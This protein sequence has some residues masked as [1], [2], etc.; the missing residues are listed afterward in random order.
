MSSLQNRSLDDPYDKLLFAKT[1]AIKKEY[2]KVEIDRNEDRDKKQVF[3]D[4]SLLSSRKISNYRPLKPNFLI[5]TE[6]CE[7]R[8]NPL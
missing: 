2:Q 3:V 8:S 7:I 5:E 4:L 1:A 6:K